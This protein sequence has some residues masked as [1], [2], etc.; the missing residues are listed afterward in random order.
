MLLYSP[1]AITQKSFMN[2]KY[3]Y[4]RDLAS[5]DGSIKGN[6][7]TIKTWTFHWNC[8]QFSVPGKIGNYKQPF[9]QGCYVYDLLKVKR[10]ALLFSPSAH[11]LSLQNSYSSCRSHPLPIL[12]PSFQ[13]S[14][15]FQLCEAHH[16]F[17]RC[18]S[19]KHKYHFWCL[20][21]IYLFIY[22]HSLTICWSEMETARGTAANVWPCAHVQLL[23]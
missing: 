14:L 7:F 13:I 16:M 22:F 9:I 12:L 20:I 23:C 19:G 2:R 10:A 8:I 1:S 11:L 5:C 18:F 17:L 6:E 21:W 3:R 15:Y 4:L